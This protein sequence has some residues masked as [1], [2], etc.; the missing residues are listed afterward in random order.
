VC[1]APGEGE[2][3]RSGMEKGEGGVLVINLS[4]FPQ[5]SYKL[6]TFVVDTVLIHDMMPVWTTLYIQMI[7]N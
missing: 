2:G 4:G 7:F 6:P 1:R 5:K 3:V